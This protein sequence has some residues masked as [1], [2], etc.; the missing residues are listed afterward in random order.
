M[1][2]CSY[3]LLMV[4]LP[5]FCGGCRPSPQECSSHGALRV[6]ELIPGLSGVTDTGE[7]FHTRDTWTN[8]TIYCIADS[9]PDLHVDTGEAVPS[10]RARQLGARLVRSA[11]GKA[12]KYFGVNVVCGK[13][14][15]YDTSMVVLCDTNCRVLGIW[16]SAGVEDLDELLKHVEVDHKSNVRK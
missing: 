11:D 9:Q 4:V 13:K 3:L 16:R 7:D 2:I 8:M 15:R 14:L 10:L 1:H 12:A 6:G 5:V